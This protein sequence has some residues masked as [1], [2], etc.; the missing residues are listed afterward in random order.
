[1]NNRLTSGCQNAASHTSIVESTDVPS[2]VHALADK[3]GVQ[4]GINTAGQTISNLPLYT[5]IKS[6]QTTSS[7]DVEVTP[8]VLKA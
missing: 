2:H 6:F 5:K 1:M 7:L 3:K 4:A 8:I